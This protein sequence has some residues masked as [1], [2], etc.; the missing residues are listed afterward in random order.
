M[1][2]DDMKGSRP[3]D[4]EELFN[5]R[6]AQA[7]NVIE[8]IFGVIKRRF[9]L[10]IAAPEY[11]AETQA[12]FVP[13][14]SALHNFIRIHDPLDHGIDEEREDIQRTRRQRSGNLGVQVTPAE[15]EW[16]SSRR[17]NIAK[18]MWASYQE[19]LKE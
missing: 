8:R 12:R 9:L 5:L 14:L 3:K 13:A 4:H 1:Y 7:C 17:D 18:A 2:Q 10:M 15:R 11:P 16:A 6:H 19:I